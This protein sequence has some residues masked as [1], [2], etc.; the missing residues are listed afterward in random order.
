MGSQAAFH[1]WMTSRGVRPCSP[2]NQGNRASGFTPLA[3][4]P[5]R[6]RRRKSSHPDA[7]NN[8][9]PAPVLLFL[10]NIS[11]YS[12]DEAQSARKMLFG[13]HLAKTGGTS[14][15][16]A[17][18]TAYGSEMVLSVGRRSYRPWNTGLLRLLYDSSTFKLNDFVFVS[19]H[20]NDGAILSF[21]DSATEGAPHTFILNRDPYDLF[22]SS[23][24]HSTINGGSIKSPEQHLQS[25]GKSPAADW[26]TVKFSHLF[27]RTPSWQ[28]ILNVCQYSLFT[29][30]ISTGLNDEFP[31]LADHLG[32]PR[33]QRTVVTADFERHE[34]HSSAN[35]EKEIRDFLSTD[36]EFYDMQRSS[37]APMGAICKSFDKELLLHLIKCIAN[38][39]VRSRVV[40]SR[41]R[42]FE[43]TLKAIVNN[44]KKVQADRLSSKWRR[45][46]SDTLGYEPDF[47][48]E[49]F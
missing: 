37:S 4:T 41:R 20:S 7:I 46:C 40:S 48:S 34:L 22:W 24:Y 14:L 45:S 15:N 3:G 21:W 17:F 25:R 13:F 18:N 8:K 30:D 36:Y 39:H 2:S 6:R 11:V 19:G 38:D 44:A 28:E 10:I 26:Y 49:V 33:R 12:E 16:Y 42:H 47:L 43:S 9:T 23:Y 27:Q 1:W 31:D 32:A 5:L 35:F 29:T